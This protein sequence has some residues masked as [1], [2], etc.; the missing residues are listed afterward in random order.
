LRA[1]F[2]SRVGAKWRRSLIRVGTPAA[3]TFLTCFLGKAQ[4]PGPVGNVL[5]VSAPPGAVIAKSGETGTFAISVQ[6][7]EGF[8]VNSDEPRDPFL[9]PL[10]LS[11]S[12]GELE[13]VSLS[14]PQPEMQKVAFSTEPA[15]VFTGRFEIKTRFKAA[16]GAKTG[17][18]TLTGKLHYQACNTQMCLTPKNIALSVPVQLEK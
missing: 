10:R 12:D 4:N 9:I 16:A 15:S 3:L 6:V 14:F 1:T 13:I 2:V 5:E 11:W 8:H 18:A 7:R 17:T